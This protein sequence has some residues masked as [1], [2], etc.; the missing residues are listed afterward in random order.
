MARLDP[1]AVLGPRGAI[2]RRLPGYEVRDE[3]LRMAEAVFGA[4]KSATHLMI[5]AGTG[6][7]KS[8]A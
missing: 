3:Q 8:F 1:V 6:V 5:E 4:I 2:S 7:G